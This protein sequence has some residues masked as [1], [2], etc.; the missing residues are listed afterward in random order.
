MK[1]TKK[2]VDERGKVLA[3]QLPIGQYRKL[4]EQ[5]EQLEEIKAY[6]RAMKRK[7]DFAPF[8]SRQASKL[9]TKN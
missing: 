5:V 4:I 8:N 9:R 3:I 6:D 7:L 2:V 1:L